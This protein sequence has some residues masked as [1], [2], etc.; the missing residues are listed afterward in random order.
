M[1]DPRNETRYFPGANTSNMGV[2]PTNLSS[3]QTCDA[4]GV[5]R[6]RSLLASRPACS[7]S[8]RRFTTCGGGPAEACRCCEA[9][10]APSFFDAGKLNVLAPAAVVPAEAEVATA[11]SARACAFAGREQ[12][13]AVTAMRVAKTKILFRW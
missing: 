10:G 1:R 7:S 5:E 13:I 6:I 2:L 9:P 12:N 3:I 11:V 4:G 8:A